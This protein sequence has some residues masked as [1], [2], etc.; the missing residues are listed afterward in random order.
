MAYARDSRTPTPAFSVLRRQ[1]DNFTLWVSR[2][3]FLPLAREHDFKPGAFH[4][5]A[6]RIHAETQGASRLVVIAQD[7]VMSRFGEG[8]LF[9]SIC[10][11]NGGKARPP[12][13]RPFAKAI[14]LGIRHFKQSAKRKH[15]SLERTVASNFTGDVYGVPTMVALPPRKLKTS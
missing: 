6:R 3:H 14:V 13:T 4:L 11:R 8:E 12:T 1:R 10:P 9:C 5:R 15:P 7:G 2:V